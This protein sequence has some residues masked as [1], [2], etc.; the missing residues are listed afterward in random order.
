ML[1]AV[2]HPWLPWYKADQF[3]WRILLVKSER[4]W[5][6]DI[7]NSL[8]SEKSI[9]LHWLGEESYWCFCLF[10]KLMVVLRVN[11]IFIGAESKLYFHWPYWDFL[12]L[13]NK[14]FHF[15]CKNNLYDLENIDSINSK[16]L[17]KCP[18]KRKNIRS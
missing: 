7:H 10:Q 5:Y 2:L 6:S 9:C 17:G 3:T 18:I 1:L 12:S 16:I 8:P 14:I 15:I 4:S 13:I 11:F